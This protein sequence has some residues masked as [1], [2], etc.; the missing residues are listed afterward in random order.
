MIDNPEQELACNIC[1]MGVQKEHRVFSCRTCSFWCCAACR[2]RLPRKARCPIGCPTALF[3]N[4]AME[5]ALAGLLAAAAT[6]G[7]VPHPVAADD[8]C[9]EV[10]ED[11]FAADCVAFL[12][13]AEARLHP[14]AAG[15]VSAA[16]DRFESRIDDNPQGLTDKYRPAATRADD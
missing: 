1:L 8:R 12:L 5:R 6:K 11:E 7:R 2:T 13:E 15:D 4:V 10:E 16:F 9:P 3:R 14:A